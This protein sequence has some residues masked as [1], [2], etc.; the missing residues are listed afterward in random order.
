MFTEK[1]KQVLQ[2]FEKTGTIG[3]KRIDYHHLREIKKRCLRNVLN[4]DLAKST[5]LKLELAKKGG[6]A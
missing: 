2:K 6:I 1:Q 3:F 5:L 4:N